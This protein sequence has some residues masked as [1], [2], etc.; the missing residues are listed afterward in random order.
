MK[1]FMKKKDYLEMNKKIARI[2]AET[3]YSKKPLY[4][5]KEDDDDL[6]DYGGY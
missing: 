5:Y 4:E 1:K 3:G 2:Y 6:M